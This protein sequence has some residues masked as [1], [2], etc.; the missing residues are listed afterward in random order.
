MGNRSSQA[1]KG[2][3]PQ[4]ALNYARIR[5]IAVRDWTVEPTAE[6]SSHETVWPNSTTETNGVK[7]AFDEVQTQSPQRDLR[8]ERQGTAPLFTEQKQ[9]LN[10]VNVRGGPSRNRTG[11]Q[12]F[13]VLCVTTPPSGPEFAMPFPSLALR[14]SL[15]VPTSISMNGGWLGGGWPI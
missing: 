14:S 6:R 4:L 12:G 5:T 3:S 7:R 8:P 9:R 1:D 2:K 10:S 13:A 15:P 11:V